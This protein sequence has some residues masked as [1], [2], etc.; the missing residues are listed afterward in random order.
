MPNLKIVYIQFK[1]YFFRTSVFAKK[2]LSV[3]KN[4]LLTYKDQSHLNVFVS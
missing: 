3:K 2:L 1:N 4:K